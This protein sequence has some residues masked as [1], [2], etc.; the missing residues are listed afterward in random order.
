MNR[1]TP[2][3]IALLISV[4]ANGAMLG[5]TLHSVSGGPRLE[6]EYRDGPPPAMRG[7][8]FSVRGFLSALPPEAREAAAQRL[9]AERDDVTARM[10]E[11]RAAQRA[12]EDA[13]LADPFDPDA[14]S[15]AMLALR[16]A[17]TNMEREIE[18][19]IIDIVADL[20]PEQRMR[21]LQQGLRGPGNGERHH[22]RPPQQQGE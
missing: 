13:L 7:D 6:R 17:R 1:A 15:D 9:R 14:L 2:W 11:V 10:R 19:A 18:S 3:I 21:A 20:P 12:V 22:R 5:L 16:T 4:L 8:G